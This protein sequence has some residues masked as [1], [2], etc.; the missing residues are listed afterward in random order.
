M[1]RLPVLLAAAAGLLAL[2]PAPAAAQKKNPLAGRID[3]L[4][5][6]VEPQVIAWRRDIHEHPELGNRE[7]RTAGIVAAELKRL[8][9]EVQT[10]VGK[11]GVVGLLR[12]GKP[13]PVVALRADMDALPVTEDRKVPFAS[14]ERTQ[15]NG[16]EV[17]IMHACGHDSHVAM[18]LGT[19]NV[20][21]QLKNDLHGTVKFIFQP[22]EEGPPAGEEG[23]AALMVKEGVLDN[24]KVDAVFG[25]HINAQT[26]VGQVKYRAGG[27]MAS[28]DVFQ[29]RVKGKSA[30]GAYP[31]LAVDPVVT[32]SQIVVALQSIVS[33]EVQ[34]TEDAAV[35]T[36]GMIH[37]GV[38]NN[39]IPEQV[40]LQGTLRA[41][42]AQTRAQLA[43][44]VRRVA[45]NIAEAAGAT[46]EVEVRAAA[47]LT[48]ND[49]RLLQ[50][51]LPTLRNVAGASA[52]SEMKAVTGAEDF[53][54][55]Q[56]KVPGLYLYLGG[57][58]KGADPAATAPHHTP[59]FFLDESGFGLG[60]RTLSNLAVDYLGGKMK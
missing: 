20:L 14:K 59:G 1:F 11:T 21:S 10:G 50:Q 42:N 53:G 56:E 29:I 22:A 9:L 34:L 48:Y 51:A 54:C 45:T 17:G 37:G 6:R 36:V 57:M 2:H 35:V 58:P 16:Q 13:G 25:L 7:T 23:G 31:W 19:A 38:R 46:A 8:G 4:S 27:M 33:R 26:E 47:P 18:L 55:Y 39:I 15:Y 52:V 12:G 3:A 28:A 44:S 60:V 49:P 41:L 43:Q 30:H 32:A 5:A 40:E 24:P